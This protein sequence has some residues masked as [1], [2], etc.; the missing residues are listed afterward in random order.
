MKNERCS[1]EVAFSVEEITRLM[2]RCAE[3]LVGRLVIS[4]RRLGSLAVYVVV[5]L[6]QLFALLTHSTVGPKC[7]TFRPRDGLSSYVKSSLISYSS[8][9]QTR[10]A[11]LSQG[12]RT[13]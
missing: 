8:R 7:R 3:F 10:S 4:C 5:D 1:S 13:C 12:A 11:C 9:A 2:R 6:G